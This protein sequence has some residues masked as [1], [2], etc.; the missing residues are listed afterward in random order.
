MT[1]ITNTVTTDCA[2]CAM[3]GAYE[4][5]T[6]QAFGG[7]RLVRWGLVIIEMYTYSRSFDSLGM[8]PHTRGFALKK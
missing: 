6:V 3:N 4:G 2:A 7:L 1:A 8:L 5:F